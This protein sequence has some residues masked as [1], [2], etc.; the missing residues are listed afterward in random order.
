MATVKTKS[1]QPFSCWAQVVTLD[2]LGQ[3][4][5]K[6]LLSNNFFWIKWSFEGSENSQSLTK[7]IAMFFFWIRKTLISPE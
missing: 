5:F 6:R 7:H 2:P 3:L 4:I 1:L